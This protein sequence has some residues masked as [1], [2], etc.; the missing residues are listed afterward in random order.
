MGESK[1][2]TWYCSFHLKRAEA[3]SNEAFVCRS[4]FIHFRLHDA[5]GLVEGRVDPP[6]PGR[7]DKISF[8]FVPLEEGGVAVKLDGRGWNTIWFYH[9]PCSLRVHEREVRVDKVWTIDP[10]GA[11]AFREGPRFISADAKGDGWL[12]A[13]LILFRVISEY[14]HQ[15]LPAA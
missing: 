15:I 7:A 8:D 3:N 13:I 6:S 14:P 2:K 9:E 4:E 1:T 5:V 12:R 10:N 11:L